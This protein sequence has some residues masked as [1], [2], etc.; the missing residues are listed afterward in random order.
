MT[1]IAVTSPIE[2][3][4]RV[5]AAGAQRAHPNGGPAST[6]VDSEWRRETGQALEIL[7]TLREATPEMV[8]AGNAA[9]PDAAEVWNAMVRAALDQHADELAG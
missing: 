3:I 8:E 6:A 5:L 9:R 7:R 4:A 1:D 2:R